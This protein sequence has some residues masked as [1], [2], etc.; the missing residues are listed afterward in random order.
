M[1]QV[2]LPNDYKATN[3]YIIMNEMYT[4]YAVKVFFKGGVSSPDYQRVIGSEGWFILG[5]NGATHDDSF[6]Y[7]GFIIAQSNSLTEE[8]DH[9]EG[10]GDAFLRDRGLLNPGETIDD[11][12]S[13]MR[14]LFGEEPDEVDLYI[15]GYK[16]EWISEKQFKDRILST[17][18][19]NC[20]TN[21]VPIELSK[22][23]VWLDQKN[24][25]CHDCS[26]THVIGA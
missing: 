17:T 11:K 2:F 15:P 9:D 24:Y 3:K 12:A 5:G 8:Y 19:S 21:D 13:W 16:N 6:P 4:G 22:E 10:W 7:G 23:V 20:G 14:D 1:I 26:K 25:L 18:C